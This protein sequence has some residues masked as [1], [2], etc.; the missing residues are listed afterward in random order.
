MS[1]NDTVEKVFHDWNYGHPKVLWGLIKALKPKVCVEIGTYRGYA[2]CWM[3]RALQENNNGGHLYC[4]DNFSL[5][6]HVSKYGD[7]IKHW[8]NN[9][10]ACGVRDFATLIKG[11]SSEVELP[12]NV[13]FAYIDGWHSYL[14][15]RDDFYAC[16]AAGATTIC[17]D[18]TLNCIG[19]RRLVMVLD[20]PMRAIKWT[21]VTL[22]NDNGLTLCRRVV[23]NRMP[24]FSQELPNNPGV[25]ITNFTKEQIAE[26]L[27]AASDING[28]HYAVSHPPYT[29]YD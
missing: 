20:N 21:S 4:V 10:T 3:A 22:D 15:A 26:H 23:P 18:D 2:A 9:L 8:E 24:T 12:K 11:L 14:Q 29:P 5:T 1:F 7:P 19:P 6:D 28:V 13:E 27:K 17:L 16:E 25:D